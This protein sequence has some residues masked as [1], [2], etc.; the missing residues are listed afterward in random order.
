MKKSQDVDGR[1]SGDFTEEESRIHKAGFK[2]I[3]DSLA[4]GLDFEQA[5]AGLEVVD[6]E[7][8][9]V[10][11]DDYVKV[12]IAEGHFDKKQS[13]E[14]IAAS[15]RCPGDL[16]K[17]ACGEMM[18]EVRIAA[19]DVYQKEAAAAESAPADADGKP[20]GPKGH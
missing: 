5:C 8:R 13:L 19:I 18:E 9:R 2:I 17:K 14:D 7:M 3:F 4:R 20:S 10:I 11:I 1:Q 15:L 16:V 6:P 12:S